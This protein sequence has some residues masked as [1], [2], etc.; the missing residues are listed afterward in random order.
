M[1]LAGGPGA[2]DPKEE[3]KAVDTQH[4]DYVKMADSW[5]LMYDVCV[6]EKHIHDQGETYLPK[7]DLMTDEQYDAYKKRAEFPMFTR[8]ALDSFVGMAMRKDL[9]VEGLDITNPFFINCDGKGSTLNDYTEGLVRHYMQYRRAG[10]LVDFPE[11]DPNESVADA[12]AKNVSVRLAFYD[13]IS[14][15][16]WKLR[17]D[18][19][20]DKL[21][22]VVLQETKDVSVSEFE[23]KVEPQYRVLKLD[24][25]VYVQELY[26]KNGVLQKTTVPHM[27]GAP[28]DFIP[29]VIH[30][31]SKVT[32]PTMLP[33]AEQNV[34]WYMK[35]ADY[36]H[37][38]HYTA[39]P[40]PFAVGVDPDDKNAPKTIGPQRIWYLPIGANCG[41]L[42][43]TG[44]G[45]SEIKASITETMTNITLLSSQILV[46]KSAYDETATA[47]SLR[48]S[49]ET[50]S[51][52][53][54]IGRLSSELTWVITV[55]SKWGGFYQQGVS[56]KINSDFIPL[57]LSGADVSAYVASVLKEGFS[58][59]TLFELLKKGDIIEGNRKF[60]D[61]MADIEKE[62]KERR[63]VELD[64]AKKLADIQAAVDKLT[65]QNQQKGGWG[66]QSA[67][68]KKTNSA[69]QNADE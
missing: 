10:T 24:K 63:A 35:D 64:M 23:H 60:E 32:S 49:A 19:N 4:P 22:L 14:I 66:Q 38:L 33:I 17:K 59:R 18:K 40:T 42:E 61:E 27:N 51:L 65:M 16:N 41:M 2:E 6:S 11:T 29:F 54:M 47:A 43:F 69:N 21:A 57:T 30:G 28:L 62:A 25:G 36:Q 55:A 26:D 45:L 12:E 3:T 1:S 37:G 53:S 52:A 13:H 34:H 44:A 31:G 15:I 68:P 20:L 50:S 39:L 5:A 7:L 58:K 48:S 46:P 9:L 67:A 8:H 56:A